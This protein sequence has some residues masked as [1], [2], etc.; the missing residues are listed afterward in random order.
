MGQVKE[1]GMS[2]RTR[3]GLGVLEAALLLG[4]LGDVLL[5][6]TPWGLNV[7]LWVAAFA[8]GA[9]ALSRMKGARRVAGEARWLWPAVV[10]LAACF[11]WRDSLTLRFLDALAICGA[12][13]L[14]ALSARGG[15]VRA[16]GV[17]EYALA[18]CVSAANALLG[19][20]PLVFADVKWKE[21]PSTGWSRHALA[22]VRGLLIAVPLLLVFGA[23]FVAADAVYEGLVQNL[24]NFESDV[25]FSHVLIFA[26]F[27][28]VT[29]GFLRG[30]L[31]AKNPITDF[32]GLAAS[33]MPATHV[34]NIIPAARERGGAGAQTEGVK[35]I[36]EAPRSGTAGPPSGEGAAATM[37]ASV[38]DEPAISAPRG[39]Y[40]FS[41]GEDDASQAADEFGGVLTNPAPSA[42]TG[43][44]AAAGLPEGGARPRVTGAETLAAAGARRRGS[45]GVVEVCVVIGSLDLLFLSFVLIQLQYFFGDAQ[46]VVAS[47][48]LTFSDY[49]RRGF[50]ELVWVAL[51]A[52]PLLLATHWL[53]RKDDPVNE[54]IFRVLAGAM[55]GLLFIIMA[56][57]VWRMRLYQLAYGQT[58]LRFYTTAFM[59]WLSA[60]LVWFTLTVLRRGRRERF[61]H[62]ALIAW[63]V[64]LGALHFV[65]PGHL[66]A[67]QNAA[68]ARA[69]DRIERFD[70]A[71]AVSLGADAAPAL[72]DALP[73]LKEGERQRVAARLV[74]WLEEERG[75]DWRSWNFSR[76]RARRLIEADETNLRDLQARWLN[77][78]QAARESA[79]RARRA[80]AP[81][82]QSAAAS[83]PGT[84]ISVHVER[85]PG[86]SP[87][88][89][90]RTATLAFDGTAVSALALG[91]DDGVRTRV[92]LFKV[93][94]SK[95]LVQ[96]AH[97][98]YS[99]DVER[100][101]LSKLNATHAAEPAKLVGVFDLDVN[102][103]WRFTPAPRPVGGGR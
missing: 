81:A 85:R 17:V 28:W 64:V 20:F 7:F 14:A 38:T 75:T 92:E 42:E 15:S 100:R 99:V 10:A 31:L 94:G 70:A 8:V 3:L 89:F 11:A 24:F 43:A 93:S 4:L 16:A 82:P 65:N 54:K 62:G 30:T 5:R 87:G 91:P 18:A 2:E 84:N 13:S 25:A 66:I 9:H 80:N 88:L 69:S 95:A 36:S 50:F 76:W 73:H 41:S 44:A 52:L 22:A 46:H 34:N 101:S 96:D 102:K 45:L 59:L 27:A 71:Y 55:V 53:L 86:T 12:L 58:E 61:A 72:L 49:A 21:I 48:G 1:T 68:Q 83:L 40:R 56:S 90:D 77:E 6:A 60:V 74:A 78:T 32:R 33:A 19:V 51:L 98:V 79:E 39:G 37:R 26:F 47:A 67:R 63:L 103:V 35:T 97:G 23:L 57:A 29:C